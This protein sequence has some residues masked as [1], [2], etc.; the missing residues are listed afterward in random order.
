VFTLVGIGPR[1]DEEQL[2]ELLHEAT[3]EEHPYREIFC[4]ALAETLDQLPILV[5]H[6]LDE[7]TP[8]ISHFPI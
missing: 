4:Y 3:P 5:N 1:A 7:N 6:L 8:A 2:E